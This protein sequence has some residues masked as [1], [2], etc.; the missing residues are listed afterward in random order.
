MKLPYPRSKS[1][2]L[3][4]LCTLSD[5]KDSP[6]LSH[7]VV[8]ILSSAVYWHRENDQYNREWKV[9]AAVVISNE[10]HC[11]ETILTNLMHRPFKQGRYLILEKSSLAGVFLRPPIKLSNQ[12]K[13]ALTRTLTHTIL[14]LQN[15]AVVRRG[16]G[17]KEP[18]IWGGMCR[19][20]RQQRRPRK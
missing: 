9:I 10:A 4:L 6:I 2:F 13:K 8:L 5:V 14:L 19:G 18:Y 3:H 16:N 7:T 12:W 15:Q 1:T 11:R 20:L 17:K